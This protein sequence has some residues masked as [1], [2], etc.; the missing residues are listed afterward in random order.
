[1]PEYVNFSK[2]DI[3]REIKEAVAEF[4]PDKQRNNENVEFQIIQSDKN[5]HVYA[6]RMLREH[7]Y[8][9]VKNSMDA[10]RNR[11]QSNKTE[12]GEITITISKFKL[13]DARKKETSPARVSI[14]IK[15]NGGGVSEETY[16]NIMQFEIGRASCR[17]RV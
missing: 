6:T 1:M 4:E 8:N 16:P 13:Q 10:I 9:I 11:R 17:E 2:V 3:S 14:E 15:D 5:L 12:G 7:I